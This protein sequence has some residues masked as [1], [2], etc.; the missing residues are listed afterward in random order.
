MREEYFD[1]V[2]ERQASRLQ[3]VIELGRVVRERSVIPLKVRYLLYFDFA[4][5]L[6][7]H[8]HRSRSRS[9]S[10]STRR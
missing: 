1:P 2:I 10:S 9:S 8:A 6:I 4:Q 3:A 7:S 5:S